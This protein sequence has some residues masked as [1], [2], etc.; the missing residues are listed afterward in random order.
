V[1]AGDGH[2]L[3]VAPTGAGKGTGLIV[4]TLL[5]YPGSLIVTDVKG[6]NFQVTARYRRQLGQQVVVLDPF[7]VVTDKTDGLNPFDLFGLAGADVESDA[8]M[9]AAQLAV[10]HEFG[11]DR[12]WEDTGRGLL[13]GLIAHLASAGKPEE[14]TPTA[15]R[16]LLYHDDLDYHLAVLLDAKGAGCPLA[17]DE[18]VSYL[19]TPSDK[20]R[21]CIRSTATTFVK[22]LGS[23]AVARALERSSFE[24]LDLLEGR[25]VTVYLV[26]PP[27]K[28]AS[29]QGVLRLWVATLLGVVLRRKRLPRRRTLFLIDEAAQLGPMDLLRQAVTLLRGYGMQ[30]WTFW[31]DLSQLRQLYKRDWETLVANAAVL[32]AF[33]LPGHGAWRGWRTVLGRRAPLLEDLAEEE[34][35][36]SLPGRRC[37]VYR[38]A[39]YLRDAAFAGRFAPN[40]RFLV[41]AEAEPEEKV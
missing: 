14:R 40:P 3:C 9:L 11:S 30:V 39:N 25:P 1:Y 21:P 32:Q 18:F 28:L 20:T 36:V 8:E 12:Y 7:G 5:T 4:P 31:Q 10:G 27:E 15:L 33:G 29:H 26:V 22:C 17:R 35:L 37:G 38:R 23:A 24:L 34:M 19:A 2:L 6:E 13:S 41:A 16:G